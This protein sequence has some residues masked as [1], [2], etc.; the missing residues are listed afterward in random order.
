MMV[1][2]KA[3]NLQALAIK[4]WS[5]F[6]IDFVRLDQVANNFNLQ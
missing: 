5:K 3:M 4:K 2:E 1:R 6:E